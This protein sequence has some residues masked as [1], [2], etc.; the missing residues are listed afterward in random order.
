MQKVVL[1]RRQGCGTALSSALSLGLLLGGFGLAAP[2]AQAGD[3]AS[4][5][6]QH[7]PNVPGVEG[8]VNVS[9]DN[10][11]NW[12]QVD[13]AVVP[14]RFSMEATWNE[15]PAA[16]NYILVQI[17]P[18][19]LPE[20]PAQDNC[21][22]NLCEAV[23]GI[24]AG[25]VASNVVPELL[26]SGPKY[27]TLTPPLGEIDVAPGIYQNV[28]GVCHTTRQ[29]L[30]NGGASLH[31]LLA[32]GF[33]TNGTP[34]IARLAVGFTG[35]GALH[36]IPIPFKVR[37]KGDPQIAEAVAP[38]TNYQGAYSS[39]YQLSEA[40]FNIVP[41]TL[42][43]SC[44]LQLTGQAIVEGNGPGAFRYRLE[45]D[46]GTASHWS[47]S[48]LVAAGGTYSKVLQLPIPIPLPAAPSGGGSGGGGVV[49]TQPGGG[50][51][52]Q[53]QPEEPVF[54]GSGGPAT[55][56]QVAGQQDPDNVHKGAA[57]LV[58]SKPDG[59]NQVVS[60][61]DSYNVTCQPQVA[62][63]GPKALQMQPKPPQPGTAAIQPGGLAAAR[64]PAPPRQQAQIPA[65]P[66]AGLT[67]GLKADIMGTTLGFVL[68]GGPNPWGSTVVIDKPQLA[69]ATGV[70]PDRNL[71]RFT[72]AGYRPF[73][74]GDVQSGP[75]KNRVY[76]GSA[77]IDQSAHNLAPKQTDGWRSFTLDLPSGLSVIR[78]VMDADKQ[79]DESDEDNTFAIRVNVKLDCGGAARRT[80]PQRDPQPQRRAPQRQ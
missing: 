54:P 56:G 68:A 57:R 16:F 55:P 29:S 66:R 69:A 5:T 39:G 30:L 72:Q 50:L 28:T 79:V 59:S 53:Q 21:D 77:T 42:T 51:A 4:L 52:I 12:S 60:A 62:L 9:L 19:S 3:L 78:V 74:K 17:K 46:N 34:M 33:T 38:E 49:M 63:G 15:P 6:F 48:S 75:F 2:P 70:G 7:A 25:Y 18:A 20:P 41:G 23:V 45:F 27:A 26:S 24:T 22:G 67:S 10:A 37:C 43:G 76:R 58:V 11:G 32:E 64:D 1:S 47:Q 61:F 40:A 14:W 8:W 35:G 31:D 36:E 65:L 80:T 13:T 71:C 44:P 73:N